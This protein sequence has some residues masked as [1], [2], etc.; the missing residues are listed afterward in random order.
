MSRILVI[1]NDSSQSEIRD[2]GDQV[3]ANQ[4]VAGGK[5]PM[6][7]ALS[8]KVGHPACNL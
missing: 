2:F 4:N 8:F 1:D 3:F 5:I 6:D 7:Q